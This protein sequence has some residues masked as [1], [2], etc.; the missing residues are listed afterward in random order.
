MLAEP[1]RQPLQCDVQPQDRRD[2]PQ[3]PGAGQMPGD[4]GVTQAV[5]PTDG[6]VDRQVTE[7]RLI[8]QLAVGREQRAD[9]V[10]QRPA[11]PV[12]DLSDSLRRLD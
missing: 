3:R 2:E 12:P 6:T 7:D 4:E 9:R 1:R 11:D 8:G 10:G 5:D